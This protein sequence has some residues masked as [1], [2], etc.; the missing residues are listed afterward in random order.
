M[1]TT[2][3][4][5]S[6]GDEATAVVVLPDGKVVAGGN[7][8]RANGGDIALARYR[9]D[10]ALDQSFGTGGRVTTSWSPDSSDYLTDLLVQPDGKVVAAGR[11]AVPEGEGHPDFAV[12]RYNRDGTLD[13]SFGSGGFAITDLSDGGYD[14]AADLVR[15]PD[16]K[17]V[18]AGVSASYST[19]GLDFALVRYDRNG[20]LDPRFGEG[21]VV[22]T[23]ISETED[24]FAEALVLQPDGKLVAG[25][26]TLGTGF[27]LARYLPDGRL[28][29]T[30]GAGGIVTTPG[31][32]WIHD[33]ALQRDGRVVAAGF[34]SNGENLDLAVARYRLDGTLDRRFGTDGLVTTDFT[35]GYDVANAVEVLRDGRIVAAGAAASPTTGISVF[36]L[37]RYHR[38]GALDRRFGSG[39]TVTTDFGGASSASALAVQHDG[40]L[41][42]AGVAAPGPSISLGD[43]ALARYR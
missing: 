24:D 10:G 5:G 30:F 9:R 11:I 23:A 12:V 40:K 27:A 4:G 38:N 20:H 2:D 16:G 41:V 29:P 26:T 28:D 37:A 15:Q 3:F 8:N 13:A 31:T 32:D 14:V 34:I 7:V 39:G 33:L 6:D 36:G 19:I 22:R 1:V 43:F 18:V 21:G 35:G 25:G 42:A 17:L